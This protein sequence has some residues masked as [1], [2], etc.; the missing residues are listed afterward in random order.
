MN[1]YVSNMKWSTLMQ[2][3]FSSPSMCQL[4]AF[5]NGLEGAIV[6]KSKV[7]TFLA[8]NFR[9][10]RIQAHYPSIGQATHWMILL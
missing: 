2:A 8:K 7:A 9:C 5:L 6:S 3:S 10:L 4:R 1:F